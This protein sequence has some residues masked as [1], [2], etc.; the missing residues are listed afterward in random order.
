[1]P[2]RIQAKQQKH[3]LLYIFMV[4]MKPSLILLSGC[5]KRVENENEFLR[6][7]IQFQENEHSTGMRL[8]QQK[9]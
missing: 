2:I 3:H 1:M 7:I 4:K 6:L 9:L 5:L 8:E